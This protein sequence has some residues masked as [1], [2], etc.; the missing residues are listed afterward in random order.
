MKALVELE[1]GKLI[2]VSNDVILFGGPIQWSVEEGKYKWFDVPKNEFAGDCSLSGDN[3]S[4]VVD[5]V[6]KQARLDLDIQANARL[7]ELE[8]VKGRLNNA[9]GTPIQTVVTDIVNLLKLKGII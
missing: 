1:T 5:A 4:L 6:K 3:Q 2:H 9:V 7:Q 8:S